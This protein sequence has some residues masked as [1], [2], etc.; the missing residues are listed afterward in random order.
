MSHNK[1][2]PDAWRQALSLVGVT[3]FELATSS[4]PRKRA[5]RLRYTPIRHEG[6]AGLEFCKQLSVGLGVAKITTYH[7]DM[8][9]DANDSKEVVPVRIEPAVDELLR[10]TH[11]I[12]K[13]AVDEAGPKVVAKSLDVSLSLVYKW[14]Q[15]PKTPDNPTASGARNPLDKIITIQHLSSEPHLV[16]FLCRACGGYFTPNPNPNNKATLRFATATLSAL[17]DFADMMH[18]AEKS[19]A[20]DGHID[21]KEAKRLRSHW[22]RL[23]GNLEHFIVSCETGAFDRDSKEA[24]K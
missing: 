22:D 9:S 16:E 7:V 24:E 20:D 14:T 12:L 1:E 18:Y 10:E 8:G 23:K 13:K 17:N 5:T 3:R 4:T 21:T 2:A 6:I 19:L 15:E 11:R